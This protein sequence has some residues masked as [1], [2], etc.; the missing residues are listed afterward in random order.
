[1]ADGARDDARGR[2]ASGRFDPEGFGRRIREFALDAHRV[3][4]RPDSPFGELIR[5]QGRVIRLLGEATGTGPRGISPWLLAVEQ[6][7]GDRLPSGP[8]AHRE[9][10]SA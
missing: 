8:F 7:I 2:D 10:L 1:M 4:R 6:Q 3:L 9:L 5:L